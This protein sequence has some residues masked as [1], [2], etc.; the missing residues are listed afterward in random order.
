MRSHNEH[1]RGEINTVCWWNPFTWHQQITLSENANGSSR[2]PTL[3]SGAQLLAV[4]LGA[5]ITV[6]I[7]AYSISR[8]CSS[9][10][11]GTIIPKTI[12]QPL[13]PI[14]ID[15]TLLSSVNTSLQQLLDV[16]NTSSNSL[17]IPK[18]SLEELTSSALVIEL[19]G[20]SMSRL[21]QI[22]K[23]VAATIVE[24]SRSLR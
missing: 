1:V 9:L 16:T 17:D 23:Q 15:T 3:Y 24:Y 18:N 21:S 12:L 13:P 5:G 6:S 4:A 20:R 7:V 8:V 14:Q 19:S 2:V 22:L 11:V 10:K